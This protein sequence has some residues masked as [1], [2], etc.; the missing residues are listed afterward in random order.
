MSASANFLKLKICV[1]DFDNAIAAKQRVAF[2]SNVNGVPIGEEGATA[3]T[4][5]DGTGTKE[6]EGELRRRRRRRYRGHVTRIPWFWNLN[7][8]RRGGR[9]RLHAAEDITDG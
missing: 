3:R 5:Q 4:A 7:D 9:R 2:S 6:L 1:T 8:L